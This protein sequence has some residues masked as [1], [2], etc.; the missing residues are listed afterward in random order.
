MLLYLD[1]SR[2]D[3][4]WALL[5]QSL[6]DG[7]LGCGIRVFRRNEKYW[8]IYCFTS[9]FE[10]QEDVDRVVQELQ[11]LNIKGSSPIYYKT[12]ILSF[13]AIDGQNPYGIRPSKYEAK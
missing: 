3:E 4:F 8:G 9:N 1:S 11:D 7:G 12:E 5:L 2:I 6:V 13:L 10:D